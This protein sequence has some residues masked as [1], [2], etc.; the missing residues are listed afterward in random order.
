MTFVLVQIER[1]PI[2]LNRYVFPQLFSSSDYTGCV[3]GFQR[4][5]IILILFCSI[6][7]FAVQLLLHVILVALAKHNFVSTQFQMPTLQETTVSFVFLFSK[8]AVFCTT[9]AHQSNRF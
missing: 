1:I 8:M 5:Q 6:V 3:Q 9:T 7:F 4:N 2:F